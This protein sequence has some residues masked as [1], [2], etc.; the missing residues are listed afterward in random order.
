LQNVAVTGGHV[1]L[2]ETPIG[3]DAVVVENRRQFGLAFGRLQFGAP[4]SRSEAS[5]SSKMAAVR[6]GAPG[7]NCACSARRATSARRFDFS[8]LSKRVRAT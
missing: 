3:E 1:V 7:S 5:A 6:L 2:D 8:N 4:S